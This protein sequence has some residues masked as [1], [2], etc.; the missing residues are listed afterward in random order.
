MICGNIIPLERFCGLVNLVDA[1]A[2]EGLEAL[3]HGVDPCEHNFA[4]DPEV[5][6]FVGYVENVSDRGEIREGAVRGE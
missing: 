5:Y 4:V 1:V 3:C 2:D 6:L